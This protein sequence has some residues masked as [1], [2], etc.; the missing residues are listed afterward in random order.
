M[1]ITKELIQWSDAQLEVFA[2]YVPLLMTG[3]NNGYNGYFDD[4]SIFVDEE[5][6]CFAK[7]INNVVVDEIDKEEYFSSV[8]IPSILDVLDYRLKCLEEL[9]S[10]NGFSQ[11][12]INKIKLKEEFSI[13][14]KGLRY[15]RLV[16]F[17]SM[18][19]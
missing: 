14:R 4:Y 13:F 8:V 10:F 2:K 5:M 11:S 1:S 6:V 19:N 16:N 18:I 9:D 15:V 12:D 7:R 17:I 3:F